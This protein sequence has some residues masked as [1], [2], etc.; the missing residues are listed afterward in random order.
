[1]K[2]IIPHG[3]ATVQQNYGTYKP[4]DKPLDLLELTPEVVASILSAAKLATY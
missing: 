3:S 2:I 4:N 1:M